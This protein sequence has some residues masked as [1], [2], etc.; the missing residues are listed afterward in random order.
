MFYQLVSQSINQVILKWPH[1]VASWPGDREGDN[2]PS[3]SFVLSE[4]CQNIFL[5]ESLHPKMQNS[6]L[7]TPTF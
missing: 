1:S 4:N 5:P 7:K 6:G 3:L 2:C